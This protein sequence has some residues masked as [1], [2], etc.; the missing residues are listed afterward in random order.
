MTNCHNS[1]CE[2]GVEQGCNFTIVNENKFPSKF[3]NVV[4]TAACVFDKIEIHIF[5]IC[6]RKFL[7]IVVISINNNIFLC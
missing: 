6:V 1:S 5:E 2:V 4:S 7:N 3:D